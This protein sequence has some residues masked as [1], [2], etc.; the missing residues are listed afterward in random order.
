MPEAVPIEKTSS[1]AARRLLAALTAMLG[2][3]AARDAV[4]GGHVHEVLGKGRAPR[5]TA[6]DAL[7]GVP[8]VWTKLDAARQMPAE[9]MLPARLSNAMGRMPVTVATS[10][11][12]LERS[13]RRITDFPRETT[14]QIAAMLHSAHGDAGFT[15]PVPSKRTGGFESIVGGP[16]RMPRAVLQH[17][18]GHVADTHA[19]GPNAG[20]L[21]LWK[22]T[23]KDVLT[24]MVGRQLLRPLH[25]SK[26]MARE[27]AAWANV[28]D[29]ETKSKLMAAA[30][31]SYDK[32]FHYN[33]APLSAGA[34]GLSAAILAALHLRDRQEP[35]E[36]PEVTEHVKTA[37]DPL[38]A[39]TAAVMLPA[40]LLRALGTA[41]YAGKLSRGAGWR[42]P[43]VAAT[44]LAVNR[45]AE[46]AGDLAMATASLNWAIRKSMES[47]NR[48]PP[49]ETPS[50]EEQGEDMLTP[51]ATGFDEELGKHAG[52]FD[53]MK[54]MASSAASA[55]AARA[56]P[57][58]PGKTVKEIGEHFMKVEPTVPSLLSSL[59]RIK[60][61]PALKSE[62]KGYWNQFRGDKALQGRH[63]EMTGIA[64]LHLADPS[65]MAPDE[66][67]RVANKARV[68]GMV[69]KGRALFTDM[70]ETTSA[71]FRDEL[72]KLAGW[73]ST[74]SGGLLCDT[75]ADVMG[76][77]VDE[78]SQIYEDNLG[79]Q[80]STSELQ[81]LAGFVA[82]GREKT[83]AVKVGPP[84][85][86]NRKEYPFVG[87]I[88]FQDLP[89]ILVE[90]K[91]G[92]TRSGTG[93]NGKEWS[94][95][96][97]DHYGEFRRTKGTD[98]DAVDVYVGPNGKST[99]VY[100]VH[101][102]KPP[103]F[104][105][106]DEDK[107]FVGFDSVAEVKACM[108]KAYDDKRFLGSVSSCSIQDLKKVLRKR[109]ARGAKLDQSVVMA[110]AAGAMWLGFDDEV[111]AF[112]ALAGAPRAVLWA[113]R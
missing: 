70:M 66:I 87:T 111:K 92:S 75:A 32:G 77:A 6:L 85:K 20:T 40:M 21:K 67:L 37:F 29:S 41:G 91:K 16:P 5:E 11:G 46:G 2:G 106:F 39:G 101:T 100:I 12:G 47:V 17:E 4:K 56:L 48:P 53:K 69:D 35:E 89:E 86:R 25:D 93:P 24:E 88:Q 23:P 30:M 76:P 1:P 65:K 98:G 78:V 60:T 22:P 99:N 38:T 102:R 97:P 43:V 109:S 72:D 105:V 107:V 64:P 108:R 27:T 104:K 14:D 36:D 52:M 113:A 80:P 83:A 62:A 34:A 55:A 61:T 50:L 94:T 18:L 10:R 84:P 49:V 79:R 3:T 13:L 8:R 90:N 81:D 95:T 112:G 42:R 68:P 45:A 63:P 57:D 110:K 59:N 19:G 103:A 51:F 73:W 74:G 33:R 96:M 26:T 15:I 71:A 44:D 58:V 31:E 82:G 9:I 54:G 28:P 7:S